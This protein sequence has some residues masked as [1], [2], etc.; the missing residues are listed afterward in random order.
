MTQEQWEL[1]HRRWLDGLIATDALLTLALL[2]R[3]CPMAQVWAMTVIDLQVQKPSAMVVI[4]N[5]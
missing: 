1:W 5:V 4:T 2:L 3:K